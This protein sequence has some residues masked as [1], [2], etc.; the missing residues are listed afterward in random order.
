MSR[1]LSHAHLITTFI[2]YP[3][4]MLMC[5]LLHE[6]LR[7]SNTVNLGEL[8][9][10]H[11]SELVDTHNKGKKLP[12]LVVLLN[13]L[14]VPLEDFIPIARLAQQL[15]GPGIFRDEVRIGPQNFLLV[16]REWG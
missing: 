9:R 15:I 13:L 2:D 16:G 3:M 1:D 4:Q 7:H 14:I 6:D 8:L 5:G 10:G 11:V 12:V